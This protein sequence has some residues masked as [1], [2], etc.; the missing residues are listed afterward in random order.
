MIDL[1]SDYHWF[2]VRDSEILKTTSST[3]YDN[4]EFVIMYFG[5]TNA[6]ASS[7]KLMDRCLNNIC[8]RL[9]ID[10]ICIYS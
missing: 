6:C 5:L 1:R 9:F 10:D 2:R 3:Q 8:N 4:Y 7:S